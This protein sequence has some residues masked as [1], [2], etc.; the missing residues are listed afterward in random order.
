MVAAHVLDNRKEICSLKF[1]AFVRLGQPDW[2]SHLKK[3]MQVDGSNE[4]NRIKEIP[5][6]SLLLYNGMDSLLEYK[7]WQ[8]QSQELK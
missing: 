6:R 3:F 7:M 2:D 1:Q 5:L 4:K 8:I